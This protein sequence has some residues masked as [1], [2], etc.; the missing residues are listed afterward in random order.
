MFVFRA[1][2]QQSRNATGGLSHSTQMPPELLL[3]SH[4]ILPAP[5]ALGLIVGVDVLKFSEPIDCD[6]FLK[7]CRDAFR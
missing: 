4:Q 5:V 2:T 1:R 3:L 6:D 7:N